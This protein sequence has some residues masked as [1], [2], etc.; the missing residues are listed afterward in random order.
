M[1]IVT[2]AVHIELTN[3]NQKHIDAKCAHFGKHFSNAVLMNLEMRLDRHHRKGDVIAMRA[4]LSLSSGE[5]KLIHA[6]SSEETFSKALDELLN[7]LS[8]QLERMKAHPRPS[9]EA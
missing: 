9:H 6:E 5:S 7:A 3:E 2:R 1:E 8:R 4:S